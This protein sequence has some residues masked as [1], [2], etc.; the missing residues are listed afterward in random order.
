MVANKGIMGIQAT[1]LYGVTEKACWRAC[2]V[3]Y[4]ELELFWEY[5]GDDELQK[6]RCTTVLIALLPLSQNI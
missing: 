4:Q 2:S 6:F 5:L 3:G 1:E